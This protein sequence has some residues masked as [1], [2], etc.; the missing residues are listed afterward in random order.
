MQTY[1]ISFSNFWWPFSAER[2]TS[3]SARND[4]CIARSFSMTI[5][6]C[7]HRTRHSQSKWA[8]SAFIPIDQ[9]LYFKA[10]LFALELFCQFYRKWWEIEQT[11]LLVPSDRSRVSI[12]EWLRCECCTSWPWPTF[13]RLR[14]FKYE[15]HDSRKRWELAKM[16]KYNFYRDWYLPSNGTILH[17]PLRDLDLNLQGQILSCSPF[18]IKNCTIDGC[19]RQVCHDSYGL[20]CGT[21]ILVTALIIFYS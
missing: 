2:S 7:M 8:S 13:S 18:V 20:R 4:I 10:K 6:I 11:L 14:F 1:T 3:K 21:V 5:L 12:I 17:I 19:P 9:D 16:L 15:Y